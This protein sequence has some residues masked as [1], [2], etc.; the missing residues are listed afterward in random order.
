VS[1][2]THTRLVLELDLAADPVRGIVHDA[3]GH[4]EPFSGWMA[5]TRTI[6]LGLDA[7]RRDS[8]AREDALRRDTADHDGLPPAIER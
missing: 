7:A 5:L 2:D 3:H 6:E 8:A 1:P 4:A